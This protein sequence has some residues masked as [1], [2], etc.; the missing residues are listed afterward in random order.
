[1][2]IK[3]IYKSFLTNN[4]VRSI[5]AVII[6]VYIKIVFFTSKIEI[7]NFEPFMNHIQ[8]NKA[9]IIIAWHGQVFILP[10]YF[11]HFFDKIKFNRNVC[12]L[13]SK[14]NDGRLAAEVVKRFGFKQIFGSSI[15]KKRKN[16]VEKSGAIKSII[17]M[18]KE[19][20]NNSLI[21][22]A[23]DGPRGPIH[24]IN[25]E[26]VNIAKKHKTP[27]FSLTISYSL[28]KQFKSWDKFQLPFP[29]GKIVIDFLEPLLTTKDS[30]FEEC[31]LALERRMNKIFKDDKK[32]KREI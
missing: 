27:I 28:K 14:H 18:M 11:K 19:I 9:A 10:A 1:M 8:D 13:S 32:S 17:I 2:K 7:H 23:P 6:K 24:K 30:D 16:C 22:L 5:V 21:F 4:T 20:K 31:N 29:F 3:P 15:N 25:S 12:V 26:I